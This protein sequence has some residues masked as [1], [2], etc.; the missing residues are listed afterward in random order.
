MKTLA[1]RYSPVLNP[2]SRD[3]G[4]DAAVAALAALRHVASRDPDR[5]QLRNGAGF[6]RSD[7]ALGHRLALLSADAVRRSPALAAEVLRMAARY[8]RQVPG[9]LA[10]AAGLTDQG[11]LL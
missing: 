2:R 4:S 6:S 1:P 5:A 3:S 9:G 7:V 8:R 10:D 11:R